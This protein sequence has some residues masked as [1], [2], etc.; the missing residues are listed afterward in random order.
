MLDAV[1]VAECRTSIGKF[2]STLARQPIR[3]G[4]AH[5]IITGGQ[6]VALVVERQAASISVSGS[7][8]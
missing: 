7:G 1:I 3:A 8:T 5:T 6:R 4:D 2:Q